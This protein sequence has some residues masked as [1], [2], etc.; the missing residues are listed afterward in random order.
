VDEGRRS[1]WSAAVGAVFRPL[2][3]MWSS[4]DPLD[5]YGLV[6][7]ASVAG[8]ALVTVAL[9]NT[10]FFAVPV[11]QAKLKVAAYLALTMAPLAV[12]GPLL[13]PLLD[14]GGFRRVIS[15]AAAGGRAVMAL[16]VAADPTALLFVGAFVILVL[17][18]VHGITKNGLTAA[19][20]PAGEGLVRAN[21][22]LGRIAA[23]G[24]LVAGLPGIL[25]VK[26]GGSPGGLRLAAVAYALCV[27]LTIRLPQ[28]EP[29]PAPPPA[30]PERTGR[31]PSLGP[32][33][34][35]TATLRGASGFLILL[36]A[37][38]LR[39]G[40]EPRYWFGV[41]AGA[42][43]AGGFLGDVAAPRLSERLAEQRIVF[44][45]IFGAGAAALL[46]LLNYHLWTL[47]LFALLAG[48]ATELGRLAFSSLM[49]RAASA[50][51]QG[52]VFVRYEVAFQV[53]WVAGAFLPALLP[54]SF[55]TGL[56]L[57]AAYYLVLGVLL[58]VRAPGRRAA[59]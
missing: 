59:A 27:I 32:A 51:V 23:V 41:L 50:G 16:V 35:G 39:S 56:A 2:R 26:L 55:R 14:H 54:I 45:S 21:A 29:Q 17:S 43:L 34:A 22:R 8:D 52:R 28:P 25:V 33:A 47:A 38:A 18:K 6:H 13:V 1:G 58:V 42:A 15:A 20:A 7:L 49:Q 19:Y 40:G 24:A 12:A 37:F 9:A 5:D 57:L 30:P 10:V 53:A 44:L 31:V 4:D 36:L 11:G 3:R 46:A 48:M